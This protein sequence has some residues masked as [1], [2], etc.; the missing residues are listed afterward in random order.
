MASPW[1]MGTSASGDTP[2]SLGP[3]AGAVHADRHRRYT[4]GLLGG[5]FLLTTRGARAPLPS[6]S[7]DWSL[8]PFPTRLTRM[9]HIAAVPSAP[10]LTACSCSSTCPA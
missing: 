8:P 5:C 1:G 9:V 7:F 2:C 3:N 6:R 4:A 10:R